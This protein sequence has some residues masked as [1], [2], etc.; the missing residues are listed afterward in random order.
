M[1]SAS[2]I[3]AAFDQLKSI[4]G[5]GD[6]TPVAAA[7]FNAS[8]GFRRAPFLELTEEDFDKGYRPSAHGAFIFAQA[9]LPLLLNAVEAKPSEGYYPPTLVFTGATASV[10]SNAQMACF[11][12]GK[13]A[14]RAISQSL[15]REFGPKGVHVSHAIIDGVIDIPRTK[16]WK[17]EGEDAKISPVAVSIASAASPVMGWELWRIS[18]LTMDRRLLRH[19]GICIPSRG[20]ISLGRLMFVRTSRNGEA[21]RMS[22]R[23]ILCMVIQLEAKACYWQT[24]CRPSNTFNSNSVTVHSHVLTC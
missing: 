4:S 1:T 3:K 6:A 8:G 22:T 17:L 24:W 16:E 9:A 7:I 10:K 12:P 21:G 13:W 11:A 23:V 14:V 15:A 5:A 19:T 18:E 20:P 2:S